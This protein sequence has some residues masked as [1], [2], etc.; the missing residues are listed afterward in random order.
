MIENKFEALLTFVM[1]VTDVH[2]LFFMCLFMRII[3]LF[4]NIFLNEITFVRI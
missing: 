4:S 3:I 2:I 1:F